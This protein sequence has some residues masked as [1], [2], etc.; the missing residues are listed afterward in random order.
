[1]DRRERNH[2]LLFAHA[3]AVA[4]C[5]LVTGSLIAEQA[6]PQVQALVDQL[7]D[8]SWQTRQE[9]QQQLV[10][11]GEA[12]RPL[13]LSVYQGS[14]DAEARARAE[15][16]LNQ[17]E[18]NRTSGT[19]FITIHLKNASPEQAFSEL[20]RQAHTHLPPTPGDL[21]TSRPW[22]AADIDIDRR[23]FWEALREICGTFGVSPQNRG[24]DASDL[25]IVAG[26]G[27]G[28]LGGDS[29]SVV[30]GPFLIT[31]SYINR[32]HYVDL[33]QPGNVRRNCNV[34]LLVAPEPKLKVLAGPYSAAI[35]EAVDEKG[36]SLRG[37]STTHDGMQMGNQ[38]V[39]SLS[40][41][42][43]PP[44]R[45]GQKIA[46]LR[47]SG[48]FLVQARSESVEIAN[49][50]SAQDVTKTVG[51]KQFTLK[52]VQ[53]SGDVF[54]VKLKIYRTGWD[55]REWLYTHPQENFALLDGEGRRLTR[56][57]AGPSAGVGD[58]LDVSL[59]F[60]QQN[61]HGGEDAGEPAKLVWDV[62]VEVREVTVP[63]EFT[64][65]PLP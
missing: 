65:L 47:G 20:A 3:C 60:Q 12:A 11:I 25:T 58:E 62:P 22:N 54:L 8:D 30:S 51:G 41:A 61:W 59:Q 18:E 15:A 26:S 27:G 29:P 33:N 24:S 6:R 10:E 23:P 40:A 53:K 19:S 57:T 50:L 14:D 35:D 55:Q 52:K 31:A 37:P 9:A 17:L 28:R 32:S 38:G 64:D 7:S 2:R 48:R 43:V 45:A 5:A 21:W 42:L 34:Q 36:Q 49:V 16:A 4:I 63:F 46:K 56:I 44:A 13:L 39:W 1:M